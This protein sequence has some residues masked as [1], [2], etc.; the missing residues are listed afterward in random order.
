[1]VTSRRIARTD[2]SVVAVLLLVTPTTMVTL[3]AGL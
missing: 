3:L 2:V 1:M